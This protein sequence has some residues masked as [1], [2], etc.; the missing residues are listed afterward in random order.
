MH[1]GWS[2]LQI[3]PP[4][5][6]CSC[7]H[8]KWYYVIIVNKMVRAFSVCVH[9]YQRCWRNSVWLTLTRPPVS[10]QSITGVTLAGEVTVRMR[11]TL[12]LATAVVDCASVL[13][14]RRLIMILLSIFRQVGVWRRWIGKTEEIWL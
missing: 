9:L 8:A 13:C 7:T 5:I 1:F 12:V 10:G 14:C 4:I 2:S 3:L 6:Q 11:E